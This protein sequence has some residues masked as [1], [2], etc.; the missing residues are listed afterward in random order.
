VRRTPGSGAES[1]PPDGQPPARDSY[2]AQVISDIDSS[3]GELEARLRFEMLLADLSF[4]FINLPSDE[5]D[6]AIQDALRGVCECLELDRS[7]LWQWP[8]HDAERWTLTHLYRRVEG[9]PGPVPMIANEHFPWGQSVIQAGRP[10]VVDSMDDLPPE[11]ARDRATWEHFGSKSAIALPLS[12]GGDPPFAALAFDS[13]QERRW[14]DTLVARLRLVAQA[15]AGVLARRRFELT[16]RESEAKLRES[17]LRLA[18]GTELAGL[19]FC[20]IDHGVNVSYVDNRARDLFGIPV[21]LDRGV[22][23]F[24]FWLARIHPDDVQRVLD[25]RRQMAEAAA[26]RVD[27]E[28]R[29]LHPTAGERVVHHQARVT[30]RDGSN[31]ELRSL[32]VVRDVTRRRTR[33]EELEQALEEVRRLRDQ[34]QQ[35]NVYL[36]QEATTRLGPARI[37]GR[38]PAILHVVEQASQVA[39]TT[40]TVLLLGETGTGKERFAS[41]IHHLSPRRDR[42]MVRVNCAAIPATLVESELFGREKGAY[43]GALSRQIGRFELAHGSTIFLDEIGDLPT[44]VQVKLLRV[45]QERQIERLGSPRP[46]TIDVRIIAA[47]NRDLEAAVRARTFREDLYYRL[48]VF[49]ITLPPLRQ[50]L[51]DIPALVEG[52]VEELAAAVGKR[53]EAVSRQSLEDLAR[54]PWPGNVRELRNAIERALIVSS[55]PVLRIEP[56]AWTAPRASDV[57]PETSRAIQDVERDHLLKVLHETGWRV[58]GHRGAAE[59]LGLKPTTLEGRMARLG[60]LRPGKAREQM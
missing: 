43:T 40:S 27:V 11:A 19:G 22:P 10:L 32:G 7:S 52:L 33:E 48:A 49:P 54:Y 39:P 23:V 60:I 53:I 56:P 34:L 51:E 4:R 1:S 8:L 44:E 28:Y 21:D 18:E 59:V 30:L 2:N 24:E 17:E 50:R 12:V 26:D 9:P 42:A 41:F 16:L 3:S 13:R 20:E 14:S 55:G 25:V 45:I 37:I 47:S 31:A 35:E 57:P 6:H 46:V 15:I 29:Y 5:V 58:R 38:S 36:R